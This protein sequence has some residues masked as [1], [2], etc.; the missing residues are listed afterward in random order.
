MSWFI[1]TLKCHRASYTRN[2]NA[3]IWIFLN[4]LCHTSRAF[5]AFSFGWTKCRALASSGQCKH[6]FP[7]LGGVGQFKNWISFTVHLWTT[8]SK[9][10]SDVKDGACFKWLPRD[11][12][13]KNENKPK[14]IWHL[15][16]FLTDFVALWTAA[17]DCNFKLICRWADVPTA[18]Q[19]EQDAH[20]PR[21]GQTCG[22][23]Q[24]F[25]GQETGGVHE[26][27]PSPDVR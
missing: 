14:I 17:N 1:A 9:K 20:V 12:F 25:Q 2:F 16:G 21:A 11:A 6:F 5:S 26:E 19:V 27:R 3:L 18:E 23:L 8:S 4:P 15:Q 22:F 7:V 10:H 24:L 13:K